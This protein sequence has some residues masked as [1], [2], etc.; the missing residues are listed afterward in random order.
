M[1]FFRVSTK[2]QGEGFSLSAQKSLAEKYVKEY[3]FKVIKT[4]SV[5]ESASKEKDKKHFYEMLDFVHQHEV[6]DVIFDKVDRACRGYRS[7]YLVE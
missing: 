3:G 1:E 7:A 2:R 4:W 5:S 6:R